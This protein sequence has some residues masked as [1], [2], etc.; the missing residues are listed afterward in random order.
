M[1][2]V[3]QITDL[4]LHQASGLRE[5]KYNNSELK[6]VGY[7]EKI[8]GALFAF[9]SK[10]NM[11][12]SLGIVITSLEGLNENVDR[13]THWTPNV[14]CYGTYSDQQK[15]FVKGHREQNL[16]QINAFV[17]DI[18]N[19]TTGY[20]QLLLKSLDL[21]FM[22]TLILE[23]DRGYQVYFV[24]REPA[25]VTR[26]THYRVIEVA[27]KISQNLRAFFS[28]DFAVDLG[29]NH[30]GIA[31][32]PRTD[33]VVFFDSNY[34]YGFAEWLNWSLK[35]ADDQQQT[36]PKLQLVKDYQGPRQIDEPWFDLLLH[37]GQIQGAKGLL[38]RNNAVLTL[39]L[40]YYASG[41]DQENCVYN[42][43]EFNGRLSVPL[44]D[45]EL[46]KTIASAYSGKY[47]AANREYI[48]SLVHQWVNPAL[49]TAELFD[50]PRG[51]H[52]F[53]KPRDQ[54]TY[55]HYAE[56]EADL[57]AYLKAHT[58]PAQ[59]L[60]KIKQ[61]ELQATLGISWSTLH[62]LKKRLSQAG[63]VY[64]SSVQ[65]GP[66][67]YLLIAAKAMLIVALL[68]K[69][70]ASDV[71]KQKYVAYLA[72]M[73]QGDEVQLTHQLIMPVA[74]GNRKQATLDLAVVNSP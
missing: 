52:K 65:R 9:R 4:I 49:T 58:S 67:S 43:T 21:G 38:G 11:A 13:F 60:L 74:G 45:A 31:R 32:I 6:P 56:R 68:R 41:K 71:R 36:H 7:Q 72:T 30:F 24:L 15:R 48:L 1:T 59:P 29:C 70:Q 20:D 46:R 23:T 33:N 12:K 61:R 44:T 63:T 19:K 35:Q 16:R 3:A 37:Q 66:R 26:K 64:F 50:Q 10:E 34:C 53:A 25:Y 27:K 22:P 5:Y 42:L 57:I 17:V 47:Q 73:L 54:R 55:S 2:E 51:W 18:D 39:A 28:T 14:F 62:A 40:A 8:K 69:K